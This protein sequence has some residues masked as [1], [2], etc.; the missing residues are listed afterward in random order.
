MHI[1][2][3]LLLKVQILN[4]RFAQNLKLNIVYNDF[5]NILY[6]II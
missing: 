6:L 1:M 4:L 3:I 5:Q 2:M